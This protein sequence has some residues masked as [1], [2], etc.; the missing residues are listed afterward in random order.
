MIKLREYG[1]PESA[2]I[3]CGLLRSQGINCEVMESAGSEL[4]PA[5]D[6]GIAVTSLYVD[7]SQAQEAL[8]I[9]NEHNQ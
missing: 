8:R 4:F 7:E 9:L 5:P 6:G 3:D 1:S 2:Y